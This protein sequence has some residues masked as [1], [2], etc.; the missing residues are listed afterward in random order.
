[1]KIDKSLFSPEKHE[2]LDL[3]QSTEWPNATPEFLICHDDESDK[4]ERAEGILDYIDFE[5]KDKNVLDFGCG[6]GHMVAEAVKRGANAIGYDIVKSGSLTWEDG[7]L[8]TDFSKISDKKYDIVILYDTLD[9]CKDPVDAL[10]QVRSVLAEKAKIFIRFHPWMGR[11]GS[12]LY[13]ELN[14]AWVHLFFSEEDLQKMGLSL[15]FIQKYPYPIKSQREWIAAADLKI[16]NSDIV[17]SLVE[18]FF[19]NPVIQPEGSSFDLMK[20]EFFNNQKFPDWQMS[21]T[22][23]DYIVTI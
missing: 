1:M 22:F 21:Q 11:H 20:K 18:P 23:N 3:L 17:K 14:K 9:H 13:K 4:R 16:V 6:E 15:E 2:M 12:H 8:T 7:L 19:R 5:L 10:K